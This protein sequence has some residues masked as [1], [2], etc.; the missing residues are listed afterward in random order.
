MQ[1]LEETRT[2][3]ARKRRVSGHKAAFCAVALGAMSWATCSNIG[4]S[5]ADV[6]KSG[7]TISE[8]VTSVQ[9]LGSLSLIFG[10]AIFGFGSLGCI[11]LA[12]KRYGS[13]SEH[14]NGRK[15]HYYR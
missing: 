15:D 14:K 11:L 10:T 12:D 8:K 13:A 3:W 6:N 1:T 4:E 7:D 9:T 5:L 2:Y